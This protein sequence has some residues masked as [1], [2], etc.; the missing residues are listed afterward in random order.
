MWCYGPYDPD[1]S[2]NNIV[3]R[4]LETKL[5]FST[6]KMF[7]TQGDLHMAPFTDE[8]LYMEQCSKANFWY[9]NAFHSVDL[10]SLREAAIQEY[11]RQPIV[12]SCIIIVRYI[13]LW[14]KVRNNNKFLEARI[15]ILKHAVTTLFE[16][17][18][19]DSSPEWVP[20]FY[21]VRSLYWVVQASFLWGARSP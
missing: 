21:E 19:R 8:T 6:G 4:F 13:V 17:G 1:E 3:D 5:H 11:F 18:R 9:Q 16:S 15:F 7:P 12:V 2:C 14:W 10:S 20:L